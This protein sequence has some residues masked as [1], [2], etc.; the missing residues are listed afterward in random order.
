MIHSTSLRATGSEM[1][2]SIAVALSAPPLRRLSIAFPTKAT[3]GSDVS[4][5][6]DL[7]F[8]DLSVDSVFE[9]LL[10]DLVAAAFFPLD[11]SAFAQAFAVAAGRLLS[12]L[13]LS[14][15]LLSCLLLSCLLLSCLLLSCLLLSC[16]LLSCLLLSCLLLSCLL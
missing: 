3:S 16:L 14:C 1:V 13:L 5:L 8:A 9:D 12:C 6:G 11:F 15:L 2:A 10:L 4:G 7:F